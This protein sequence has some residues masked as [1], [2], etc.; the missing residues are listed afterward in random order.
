[1]AR[2][3][4]IKVL[5]A[6]RANLDAQ[7]AANGLIAGEPYLIT[8]ESRFAV[9]TAVN[10]YVDFPKL[11]ELATSQIATTA[12]NDNASSGRLGEYIA[13]ELAIGSAQAASSN[14]V[15]NLASISLAAGD[16]D[17]SNVLGMVGTTTGATVSTLDGGAS[18]TS[19]TLD[20]TLGR[21]TRFQGTLA[22]GVNSMVMPGPRTRFS[23]AST[24]TVY[25]TA[26]AVYSGGAV[27]LYGRI[28]ARR[29]R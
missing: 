26:R 27:S 16:W 13:A 4:P 24:T 18:L 7:R 9:A 23:L 6:T 8:D 12:T 11:S 2:G 15:Y 1:M 21:Y 14:S 19:G 22:I 10:A 5:R 17:V 20:V 28:E 29:V 3:N 25:L